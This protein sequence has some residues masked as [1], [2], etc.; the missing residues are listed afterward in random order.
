VLVAV[1]AVVGVVIGF[2]ASNVHG[3]AGGDATSAVRGDVKRG[4]AIV[5]DAERLYAEDAAIAFQMAE[6]QIRSEVDEA[7]AVKADPAL[8]EDLRSDARIQV[9]LANALV[10]TSSWVTDPKAA[11]DIDG[12][13]LLQ[14]LAAIRAVH[15]DLTNIDVAALKASAEDGRREST[16]LIGTLIP[17]AV[18]VLFASLAEVYEA[19]RRLLVTVGWIATA[20]GAL[21]AILIEVLI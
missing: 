15:P 7:H 1:T 8:T 10:H 9:G 20:A 6:A 3:S 5:D 19:R 4:A 14:R 16:L 21:L 17:L 18:A 11:P 2:H 13:A 12:A